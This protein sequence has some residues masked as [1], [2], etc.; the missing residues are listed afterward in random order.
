MIINKGKKTLI[1]L[2]NLDIASVTKTEF[3]VDV[4]SNDDL[5]IYKIVNGDTTITFDTLYRLDIKINSIGKAAFFFSKDGF[6]KDETVSKISILKNMDTVSKEDKI[7]K[8]NA[9]LEIVKSLKPVLT[10]FNNDKYSEIISTDINNPG[11]DFIFVDKYL[12]KKG[13]K[14]DTPINKYFYELGSNKVAVIFSFIS[15][16]IASFSLL[17]GMYNA[18]INQ[19]VY[20]FFFLIYAV[21]FVLN[22]FI[23]FDLYRKVP[24]GI[25]TF[26]TSIILDIISAVIGTVL[27]GVYFNSL[28]GI[29]IDVPEKSYYLLVG[30]LITLGVYVLSLVVPLIIKKLLNKKK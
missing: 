9:L 4:L 21:S 27:F 17:I 7:R 3:I 11:L 25:K 1:D 6:N 26:I 28:K 10:I 20:I 30:S 5:S 16:L 14:K 15:L 22:G 2:E 12:N 23:M 24:F 13:K 8:V 29:P 19:A 18:T